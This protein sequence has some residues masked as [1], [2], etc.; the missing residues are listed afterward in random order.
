MRAVSVEG[1]SVLTMDAIFRDH[2]AWLH[3][4]LN[5]R[6]PNGHSPEDVASETILR[7]TD[8][9]ARQVIIEPRA[10][11]TTIARRI[12]YDLR[13]KNDLQRAYEAALTHLP[14]ALEPSPEEQ[15][16][17]LE[18][19]RR[20]DQILRP[21]SFKARSAFLLSQVDG[22]RHAD[23]AAILGLSVSMV[24]KHITA[25]MKACYQDFAPDA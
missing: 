1:P 10:M 5:F 15:L 13:A 12:L 7:M 19:L 3:R 16:L 18:A 24:R 20:V 22:L 6:T 2:Y 8:F 11:M 17:T 25:A 9:A 21:L 14:A 4:W 23:I